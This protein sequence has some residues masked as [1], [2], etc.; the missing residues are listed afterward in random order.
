MS[1]DTAKLTGTVLPAKSHTVLAKQPEWQ[2][3]HEGAGLDMQAT[4][5]ALEARRPKGRASHQ[6]VSEPASVESVRERVLL[7]ASQHHATTDSLP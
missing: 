5:K 6:R 1:A 4:A 7:C 2:Y 3:L